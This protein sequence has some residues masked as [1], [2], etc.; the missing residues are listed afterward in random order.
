MP[1]RANELRVLSASRR[2]ELLGHFPD[3]LAERVEAA[4]PARIHTVV[5]WSK[6][7]RPLLSHARLREALSRVGQVFLHWTVTGLGGTFLEPG[8]P[9]AEAQL[10]LAE[11]IVAYLGDPRRLHWRY[12]PLL[13]VTRDNARLSNLDLALFRGLAKPFARV[14]VTAVHTSF[15]TPYP[16]LLRR[17]ATAG[18]ELEEQDDA[19]RRAF[20]TALAGEAASLGMEVKT[21]SEPG[22]PRQRCIDGELLTE[23][24]PTH[25]QAR[26][27]RGARPT[28]PLRLHGQ[29]RYRPLPP[30]PQ[31]LPLL[32]CTPGG[33]FGERVGESTVESQAGGNEMTGSGAG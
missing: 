12:D 31:S 18:V 19:R 22:F 11:E 20:L 7:P 26:T 5:L 4:D 1:P 33:V 10:A 23:L 3:L 27:D 25:A 21:C 17:F 30:L 6:D 24:H 15:A 32:L 2:T 29:P 14:G 16:K 28:R 8:V 13:S 9:S